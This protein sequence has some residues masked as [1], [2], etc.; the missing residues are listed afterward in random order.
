MRATVVA[1]SGPQR[2]LPLPARDIREIGPLLAAL[3]GTMAATA[4]PRRVMIV[5]PPCAAASRSAGKARRASSTP[6]VVTLLRFILPTVQ[7]VQFNVKRHSLTQ[8][9]LHGIR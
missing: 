4:T 1:E 7:S 8:D 6:F 2:P 5:V 9:R 3:G